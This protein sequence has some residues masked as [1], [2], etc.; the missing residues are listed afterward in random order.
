MTPGGTRSNCKKHSLIAVVL[1]VGVFFPALA[2]A[3]TDVQRAQNLTTCLSGRYTSLCRREWLTAEELRRVIAAER[4]ENLRV[5][6]TG[7]YPALCRKD[8]LSA[9][10]L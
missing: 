10:E 2:I 4:Q 1:L 9:Q 5:C 8:L 7:K 6:L 3:Q